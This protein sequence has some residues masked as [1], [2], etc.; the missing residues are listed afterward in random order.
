MRLLANENIAGGAVEQLRHLG[1]DV[2]WAAEFA[3][4]ADDANLLTRAMSEQRILVTKDKDFGELAV[5]EGRP[6]V[7]VVLLRL[8]DD[9]AA[10]TAEACRRVLA[11]VG[12]RIAGRL[13]VVTESAVRLR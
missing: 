2:I 4:G 13:A 10:P 11:T 7:G 12:G 8:R 1:H 6:H 3:A 5:R 9:R